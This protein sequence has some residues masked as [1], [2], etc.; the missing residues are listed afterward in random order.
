MLDLF[1]LY[2]HIAMKNL[3]DKISMP[4]TKDK[5]KK[6][7]QVSALIARGIEVFEDEH[8][9]QEWPNIPVSALGNQKPIQILHSTTGQAQIKTVL[10]Q[11]EYGIYS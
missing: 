7:I 1:S 10:T 3:F 4:V 6:T 5:S 9:F 2:L 11:I 8:L